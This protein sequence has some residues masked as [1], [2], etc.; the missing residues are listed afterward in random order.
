MVQTA[1]ENIS[2]NNVGN[3][4]KKTEVHQALR[5]GKADRF[6][7]A[8]YYNGGG[9]NFP[10]TSSHNPD[11]H[12]FRAVVLNLSFIVA[13]LTVTLRDRG[14]FSLML[15]VSNL[16]KKAVVKESRNGPVRRSGKSFAAGTPYR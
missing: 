3:P 11:M 13:P 12:W 5:K 16:E 10:N 15:K 1:V 4:C 9:Q 14:P 7:A 6:Y 2:T 8:I